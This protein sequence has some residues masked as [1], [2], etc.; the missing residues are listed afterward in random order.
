MGKE[1]M[2]V[3]QLDERKG[4]RV[5]IVAQKGQQ[6]DFCYCASMAGTK[7]ASLL[8]GGAWKAIFTQN[9]AQKNMCWCKASDD[10]KKEMNLV[11]STDVAADWTQIT[12]AKGS[13]H[14]MCYCQ[15][16]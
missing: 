5:E 8:D 11:S 12:T 15:T 9:K 14:D 10:E 6:K 2:L 13:H 7:K 1:T 16:S 3:A 4:E